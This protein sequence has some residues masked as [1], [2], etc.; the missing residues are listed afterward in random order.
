MNLARFVDL[1]HAA[2][3]GRR[4]ARPR[5][6]RGRRNHDVPARLPER[7]D[8]AAPVADPEVRCV[9][10]RARRRRRASPRCT[11]GSRSVDPV[12]A[13]RIHANDYKRIERALEVHALTGSP[14]SRLQKEATRA[15]DFRRRIHVAHFPSRRPRRPHRRPG[16]RDVRGGI[17]RRGA[18][19]PGGRRIRARVGQKAWDTGRSAS[20]SSRAGL[21]STRR[22]RSIQRKTRLLRAPPDD[23]APEARSGDDGSSSS[24][25]ISSRRPKPRSAESMNATAAARLE[26]GAAA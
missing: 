7:R 6:G 14:I 25:P 21:R 1:A 20:T 10:A 24:Q 26:A 22:S 3:R 13:S 23:V 12:A 11:S 9:A 15:P 4:V 19:D 5:A 16:R 8:L 17:R 2:R 18:P